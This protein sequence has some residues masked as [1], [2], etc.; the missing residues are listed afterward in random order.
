MAA[1]LEHG[2]P[3]NIRELRNVIYQA[4][5][6]KRAG[7]ELLL[8]AC[9]PCSTGPGQPRGIAHPLRGRRLQPAARGGGPRT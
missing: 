7:T 9:G 5:V 1:L 3:G 4:L 6:Y 2:W 8:S